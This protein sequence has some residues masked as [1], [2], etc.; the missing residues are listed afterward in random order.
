VTPLDLI[1]QRLD[2][3]ADS[4]PAGFFRRSAGE[5]DNFQPLQG[6]KP[7]WP[8]TAGTIGQAGQPVL[9]EAFAPFPHPGV[10][11]V[12]LPSDGIVLPAGRGQQDGASAHGHAVLCPAGAAESLQSDLFIGR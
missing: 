1:V 9:G 6:G 10:V 5:G 11:A 8:A 4:G 12:E 7:P 3:P 2:R